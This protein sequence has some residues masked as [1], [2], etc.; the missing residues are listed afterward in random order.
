MNRLRPAAK[1]VNAVRAIGKLLRRLRGAMTRRDHWRFG[2][3]A[4]SWPDMTHKGSSLSKGGSLGG[5]D[6]RR[7]EGVLN[8]PPR[9]QRRNWAG[10][11]A[12]LAGYGTVCCIGQLREN[13]RGIVFRAAPRPR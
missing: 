13:L 12:A 8:L 5:K 2:G 1:Q 6:V 9:A 10:Q 7:G 4:E 3:T 11:F